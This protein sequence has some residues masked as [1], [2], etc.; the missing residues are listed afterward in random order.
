MTGEQN[1]THMHVSSEGA[2][3]DEVEVVLSCLAALLEELDDEGVGI[4]SFLVGLA[5]MIEAI[6]MGT[7]EGTMH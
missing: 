4:A 5:M 6:Q 3:A 7:A 1:V 2:V